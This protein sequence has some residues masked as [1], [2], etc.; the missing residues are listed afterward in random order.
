MEQKEFMYDSCVGKSWGKVDRHVPLDVRINR[1]TWEDIGYVA[2]FMSHTSL[3]YR[4]I[5]GCTYCRRNGQMELNITA[6]NAVGLPYG[7]SA[8]LILIYL[9]T[10]AKIQDSPHIVLGRSFADFMTRIGRPRTGGKDGG[11]TR[12]KEQLLRV[13]ACN[14]CFCHLQKSTDKLLALNQISVASRIRL[15]DTVSFVGKGNAGIYVTLSEEFMKNLREHGPI[16]IDWRILRKIKNSAQAIDIYTWLCYR[17]YRSSN[18]S[19]FIPWIRLRA[20][21]GTSAKRESDVQRSFV[22]QLKRVLQW[23]PVVRF[24][25]KKNG[26]LL[27]PTT[28]TTKIMKIIPERIKDSDA[29][30]W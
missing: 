13:L 20:Q 18:S 17:L 4:Q 23:Y 27:T 28:D 19:F 9:V 14:I 5:A 30:F 24:K 12:V 2:Q 29:L 11:L 8:R 1:P 7:A 26:L 22:Y 10:V 25:I 15:I 21:F 16:P 6:P 3:P